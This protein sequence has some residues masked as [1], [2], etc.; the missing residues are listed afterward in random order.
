MVKED[1]GDDVVQGASW[2]QLMQQESK[3]DISIIRSSSGEAEMPLP[4]R[5]NRY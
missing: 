2:M 3:T 1:L 4:F 5:K